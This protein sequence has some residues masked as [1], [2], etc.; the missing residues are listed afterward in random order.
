MLEAIK[1]LPAVR[2]SNTDL[3]NR[4]LEARVVID[5]DTASRLSVTPQTV[6]DALYSAFGQ[7]RCRRCI[8]L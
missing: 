7:G 4:G 3:Q 1:L 5:R 6:D 8:S 2:E